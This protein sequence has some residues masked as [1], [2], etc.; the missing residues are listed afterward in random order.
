MDVA[1]A[2]VNRRFTLAPMMD[3]SDRHCRY[4][5]RLISQHSVV[6][7]EM[8]TTAALLHGGQHERH[9]G[10]NEVEHPIALQL[11]G[12]SPADLGHCAKLAEDW[13]YDEVNLNCGCP[14]DRVQEGKIGA[15]LM[16]EPAL[17][18][19]CIK[20]MQDACSIDV[21]IKHRIG[22]D[23]MEDYA[24]MCRFVE[25]VAETGCKTFIVHARKA[26]LKGLSPKENREVPPLR[27]PLVHQLKLEYPE[28]EIIINGG[29]KNL[30][31]CEQ[32]LQEVD[33]V[34]VGREAYSNPYLLAEV[35]QRIYGDDHTIPDRMSIYQQYLEY[36]REQHALGQKLHFMSRHV[37]GL[38]QGQAGAR[39]FRRHISENIHKSG[40]GMDVL[41][42]AAEFIR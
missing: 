4:L 10:Y 39:Q 12:S 38:F 9:L 8:V 29:L 34:M 5:W 16:A 26:W 22:I 32:Q 18:A 40:A 2:P 20:A 41:E 7:S 36:C 21:T 35:D 24:D 37:L 23:D 13:G 33:G 30:D 25:A 11:G 6:Y 17:V 42:A 3:W 31:D 19:D 1:R 28:L 14:S 15:I 27:Y